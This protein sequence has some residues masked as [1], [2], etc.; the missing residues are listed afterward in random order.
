MPQYC[1][2]YV[3]SNA[4]MPGLVKIGMTENEDAQIRLAQLY[5]TGV[6][7]PFTLEF[8]CRVTNA[9]EVERALHTAFAPQRVNP[10]REFFQ[11]DPGQAIAILRLLNTED[12]TQELSAQQSTLQPSEVAAGEQFRSRRPWLNFIEMNIPIGSTLVSTADPNITITVT[13]SRKVR[14]ND[15]EMSITAATREALALGYNVA[16]APYWTFN[17]RK[18]S[19]IYDETY[20]LVSE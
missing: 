17:G 7:F 16:P 3:L 14:L 10:R 5:T 12:A 9:E 20:P 6:P 18:L 15:A 8:A 2:V 19:E 11:I 1:I 13:G 4:A